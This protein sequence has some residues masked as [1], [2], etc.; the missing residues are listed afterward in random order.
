MTLKG[1]C[2]APCHV[3]AG[4]H[5]KCKQV[6]RQRETQG[7]AVSWPF[8][9]LQGSKFMEKGAET[10]RSWEHLHVRTWAPLGVCSMHRETL[11]FPSTS[12]SHTAPLPTP[13]YLTLAPPPHTH[14]RH[15]ANSMVEFC[16]SQD[17]LRVSQS[18]TGP[19]LIVAVLLPTLVTPGATV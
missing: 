9:E 12:P 6:R 8:L 15:R 3:M 11:M 4:F 17:F 13:A 1:T 7:P 14:Y 2:E 16:P 10:L 19:H 18:I 5:D